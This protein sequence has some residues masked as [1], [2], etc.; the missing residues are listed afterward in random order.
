MKNIAKTALIAIAL[1]IVPVKQWAQQP[2]LIKVSEFSI[3][4]IE[5]IED[6][7][8]L[9]H[10]I[11]EKGY[12]CFK[13]NTIPNTVDVYVP[14]DASDN[15]S[16]FDFIYNNLISEEVNEFYYLGKEM[17]GEL[18]VQWRQE[19]NDDLFQ[20]LYED[21]TRGIATDNAT[22]ET[23][24]PFCTDNGAYTFPAGVNSGSPCGNTTTAS[25]SAPYKCSGTPG[26][27]TNCLST[28]PNPA[29]YYLKIANTGNLNIKIY[30]SPRYDIDF[31]CW[32]PFD[33]PTVACSQL[34]CSNIVDCSYAAG[35][36]DEF[37]HI[38]NAVP[39]KYYILLLTNYSNQTCN[40]VFENI[41]T[42][43]TD[44][45]IMPP[46]VAN[47]G[48]Y[49]A[50]E[51]I[52]LTANGQ[53]GSSYS[54]TGPGG[55]TSTQQNPIRTNCTTAM[56]GT[57]TCTI[58]LGGQTNSATTQ[59]VVNAQPVANAGPDQ[60][61]IYGATAQLSGSGGAGSF[62]YQWAPVNMV[63]N[64]NAQNTQTV[65]LTSD[66][67]YYLTV[68][69]PQGGCVSSDQVTIHISGS[70]MVVTPGDDVSICQ[71]GS[72]MIQANAGGGTGNFTYSWSPTTG[73]SNPTASNPI[74]SPSQ[75][76][77]YT[78]TVSDGMS[79]QSVS[80]TV[81]VN[82]IVITHEYVSVCPNQPYSWHGTT[83]T[84][85]G[86]YEY[87]TTT[88][89]GCE[90][91]DYLHLDYY[92]TYDETSVYAAICQGETYY[93]YGNDYT[94]TG[95][96]PITLQT[97]H[98]CD[99][100]VR[101]NLTVWPE[102]ELTENNVSICPELLPYYFY[103]EYYYENTDVTVWDTDIH[104][105]DS[106]VRLILTVNDYYQPP[107]VTKYVGYYDS[108]SYDWYIPEAGTTITYT[109]SG[110][111]TEILPTSACEGIFTLDLHF[112][113]IPSTQHI[114][115]TACDSYDWWVKGVKVGTYTNSGNYPYSIPLCEQEGNLNTQYMYYNPSNPNNPTPC[116]EDYM[117]DLA[118]Y[119]SINHQAHIPITA[120]CDS[121][122][123]DWFGNTI[124]FKEDGVYHFPNEAYPQGHTVHGN[125]DTIM[126]VTVTNMQY[127]PDPFIKCS[128]ESIEFPDHPITATEFSVNRY[129]YHVEDP[130]SE[131]STWFIDRCEWTISKSS[132]P[133]VI[134]E[135]KLSCT[136]YAMDWVPD[137][138]WLEFKAVNKC[139]TKVAR[140][141]LVP[142]F[143]GVEEQESYPASVSVIP[144]PND[145]QM[146]LRFSNM[147]GKI[148]VKVFNTAGLVVDN[149]E[150][151]TT[152]TPDSY[153]YSMKR[154]PN[155]VYCFVF[156]DGK[157]TTTSKVVIIH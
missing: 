58:S 91:T 16:D 21:F 121:V 93:Y 43:T 79:T 113:H 8:C 18:F 153:Y 76:T 9:L 45:G 52:Q 65:S 28:A 4:D 30:S 152:Q 100:I 7:V 54:W 89:Q 81:T 53:S 154:L 104:G 94:E 63:V 157:R 108:P 135:D 12:Y 130:V 61:I 124:Y 127:T 92:P 86:V 5:T 31:D 137:T 10:H 50:G 132:W 74:A 69:N 37:C 57:Y 40:I 41:G 118:V 144:N 136:V 6:R 68:T 141:G 22:C 66:Q 111:H 99:S 155:G 88:A 133:I 150:L 67:T 29:F 128:D 1:L 46:L 101:L 55:W 95:Q 73:L 62:S 97:I 11:L 36:G 77:T 148:N 82:D 25:C 49:C 70:N 146:E 34:S 129:T 17:R 116:T 72:A 2:K 117:L 15:L 78:C 131:I 71:G 59:V 27:S 115:D 83:Y 60:T 105:C 33:S 119:H 24:L 56:S 120:E 122:P 106:A 47:D 48:P 143:Y 13:S 38:N 147:E 112:G 42:G 107:T 110:M 80:V 39:G 96:Y 138:I 20:M 19:L 32:G 114:I 140:Y 156:S 84:T 44:C 109:E 23:A 14:S 103:G 64:P 51:T 87:N 126:T 3:N 85:A 139:S 98:G 26:Q 35:T 145:G 125:C 134:S 102:N 151:H 123:F 75:T 90:E 149:F 142:S